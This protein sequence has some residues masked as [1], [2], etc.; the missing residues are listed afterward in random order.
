MKEG[1][2]KV[3]GYRPG[4]LGVE[5]EGFFEGIERCGE[6]FEQL[7]P[8]GLKAFDRSLIPKMDVRS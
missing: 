2:E 1:S 4:S 8:H 5:L 7:G 6:A 3:R